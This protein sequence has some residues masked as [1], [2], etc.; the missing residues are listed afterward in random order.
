MTVRHFTFKSNFVRKR[1]RD[2]ET[3][4][5][6]ETLKDSYLSICEIITNEETSNCKRSIM[7]QFLKN[8]WAQGISC[9]PDLRFVRF[10]KFLR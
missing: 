2:L 1:T 6:V 9:K 7:K 3:S 8:V 5:Q 10:G 4:D